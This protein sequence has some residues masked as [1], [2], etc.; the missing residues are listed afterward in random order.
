MSKLLIVSTVLQKPGSPLNTIK[1]LTHNQVKNS[2]GQFLVIP[3]EE[4]NLTI[5]NFI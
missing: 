5:L 1:Q 4:E 2:L 3:S